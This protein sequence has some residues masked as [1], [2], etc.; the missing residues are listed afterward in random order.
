MEF[1]VVREA[2]M[3]HGVPDYYIWSFSDFFKKADFEGKNVL[4]VGGSCLP[5]EVVEAM[6]VESWTSVDII[7]HDAGAYQQSQFADHY[8]SLPVKNLRDLGPAS[9]EEKYA[10]YDGDISRMPDGIGEIFDLAVS[11][12]AFEHILTLPL[13]LSKI[14]RSLTQGGQLLTSFGPIWSCAFGSHFWVSNDWNFLNDKQAPIPRHAHLLMSPPEMYECL[15]ESGKEIE[16]VNL[17]ISQIYHH[18]RVNRLFYD[19][20]HAYFRNSDF[21][22]YSMAPHYRVEIDEVLQKSLEQRYPGR[23]DFETYSAIAS[24]QKKIEN[25]QDTVSQA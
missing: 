25:R 19:D 12:N 24:L 21:A 14:Y 3:R 8:A 18:Q 11:V 5:I 20:Y 1:S 22:S 23:A 9:T 7:G 15:I 17:A 10:I 16:D 13:A 6:G 4:E 2:M